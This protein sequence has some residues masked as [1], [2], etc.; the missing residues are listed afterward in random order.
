MLTFLKL[1]CFAIWVV[2]MAALIV[3][4]HLVEDKK[5]KKVKGQM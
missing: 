2:M 3:G 5:G 4:S 1:L